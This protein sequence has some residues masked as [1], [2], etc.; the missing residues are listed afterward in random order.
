MCLEVALSLHER[1]SWGL[2]QV[3]V[4]PPPPFCCFW[5]FLAEPITGTSSPVQ[6]HRHFP[7]LP[8]DGYSMA[9]G[10]VPFAPLP[11]REDCPCGGA[12]GF[13]R[14]GICNG[15]EYPP[16]VTLICS[17]QTRCVGV[18]DPSH[19]GK[20]PTYLSSSFH[21]RTAPSAPEGFCCLWARSMKPR[22]PG[23][24]GGCIC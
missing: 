23:F 9:F 5:Q 7:L 16:A 8:W 14:G 2:L 18:E 15:Q 3:L 24:T 21:N 6:G 1:V 12:R 10:F 20:H 22:H 11:L 4:H 13:A 19:N 17:F